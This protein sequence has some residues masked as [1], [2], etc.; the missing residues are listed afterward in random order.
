[1]KKVSLKVICLSLIVSAA[2]IFTAQNICTVAGNGTPGFG[3]D[4]AAATLAQIN[5]P[6]GVA[7][8]VS[9]NLYIA[10][11]NNYL[12]R[13]VSPSGIISIYAGSGIP[14]FFG[15]GSL[16]T[17]ARFNSPSGIAVDTAGNVYFS[18]QFGSR[19]RKVNTSGII[20]TFAGTGVQGYNGD[21]G[22]AINAALNN[23]AGVAVDVAG[24]VYIADRYNHKIRKIN[25]SGIISNYAGAG[26]PGF[27]GDGGPAVNARL[28]SP[29]GLAVDTAGNL[30]FADYNNSR[31]RK[32][33]KS[34]IISTF[35]GTGFF[36]FDGDG[37]P[38]I[39]AQ[40]S[41]PT[42]VAVDR[43][44]KV[45]ISDSANHRIRKVDLSGV[46]STLA[47]TDFPGFSGDGGPAL[48]AQ[49]SRASGMAADTSG[50][51]FI[52]DRNNHRI[53]EISQ[54]ICLAGINSLTLKTNKIIIFPN[55]NIG[56]FEIKIN[57]EIKEGEL[58]LINS[59][60]QI[61]FK[62]KI[63]RETSQINANGLSSG[64]YNCVLFLD[65]EQINSGRLI[66]E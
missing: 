44:G 2:N 38:A 43:S 45:Y 46:I 10:D 32:I 37:G 50:N 61:I 8:D 6:S 7:F 31:I 15:D 59:T 24:N 16:A 41:F 55:P 60:G 47:G 5:S 22:M 13:K 4:G 9:N 28:N 17:S 27:A 34:G 14:G 11:A 1:M 12:I 66:I 62:Q 30:Y 64:L 33:S 53:R 23:P 25:T 51:L 29:A 52:A 42:A 40:L 63:S 54:K 26:T 3:G 65:K 36:G 19:I 48:A 57:N 20:S 21:G 35:A 58:I 39:N 49:L 56:T 18:D